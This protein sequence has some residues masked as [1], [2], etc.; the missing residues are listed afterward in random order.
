MF[1]VSKF[2]AR[3]RIVEGDRLDV[4]RDPV[5]IWTTAHGFNMEQPTAPEVC[6]KCGIDYDEA[7]ALKGTRQPAI[8]EEQ[9]VCLTMSHMAKLLPEVR[10]ALP[11]FE[12]YSDARQLALMDVAWVGIGTFLGFHNML[13]AVRAQNWPLAAS[14]LLNSHLA[15][16]WGHRAQEDAQ[17]LKE[18]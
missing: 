13:A 10:R 5:G 14:E 17:M 6:A 1:Q 8:T 2:V 16:Q 7:M 18:G 9:A 11:D 15:V 4:Y 3:L 12:S